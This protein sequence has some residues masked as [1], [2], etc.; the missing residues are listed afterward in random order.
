MTHP[1][2]S[3]LDDQALYD[4]LVTLEEDQRTEYIS[5]MDDYDRARV[6][7]LLTYTYSTEES[8]QV[9]EQAE[10]SYPGYENREQAVEYDYS[11][12][13]EQ[14]QESED[15]GADEDP[16]GTVEAGEYA[17]SQTYKPLSTDEDTLPDQEELLGREI[18]DILDEAGSYGADEQDE[19]ELEDTA[20]E[21]SSTTHAPRG[22]FL[23]THRGQAAAA[24]GESESEQSEDDFDERTDANN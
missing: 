7:S 23:G 12:W 3:E 17:D 1:Q 24:S 13:Q 2:P 22:T 20:S 8:G 6:N 9:E 10:D 11:G 14:E 18:D 21:G 19:D 4:Y 5:E 15:E 16:V